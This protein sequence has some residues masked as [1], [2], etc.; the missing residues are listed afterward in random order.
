M[1]VSTRGQSSNLG[2]MFPCLFVF[3]VEKY[4]IF[5]SS[6][7]IFVCFIKYNGLQ[8]LYLIKISFR[9]FNDYKGLLFSRHFYNP[10]GQRSETCDDCRGYIFSLVL[11][12]TV[13]K[14]LT[15]LRNSVKNCVFLYSY[16]DQ[17]FR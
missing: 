6:F 14:N 15:S 7:L 8:R 12:F 4:K 5:V 17:W 1:S 9:G 2:K 13:E 3:S 16:Q 11:H 10:S